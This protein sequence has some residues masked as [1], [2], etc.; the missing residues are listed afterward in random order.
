LLMAAI[1]MGVVAYAIYIA[2]QERKR[3]TKP[4]R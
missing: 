1:T 3:A 2:R 4:G